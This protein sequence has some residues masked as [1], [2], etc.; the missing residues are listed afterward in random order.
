MIMHATC[1]V[2]LSTL[3]KLVVAAITALGGVGEVDV[4]SVPS[5]FSKF[6]GARTY[7][8]HGTAP[9]KQLANAHRAVSQQP[10]EDTKSPLK[11]QMAPPPPPLQRL[12]LDAVVPAEAPLQRGEPVGSLV[13][14][15]DGGHG[16][17]RHAHT[18]HVPTVQLLPL[19]AIEADPGRAARVR[20]QPQLQLRVVG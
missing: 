15:G 19:L 13:R 2:L 1:I 9:G 20:G 17:G 6:D 4:H 12:L 5:K 11:T 10:V 7:S 14:L 3:V 8:G 18:H 16:V